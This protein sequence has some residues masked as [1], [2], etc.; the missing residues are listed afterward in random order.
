MNTTLDPLAHAATVPDISS[1]LAECQNAQNNQLANLGRIRWG[2]AERYQWRDGKDGTGA[3]WQRNVSDRTKIVRPYDGCPD[4]DAQITDEIC[5]NEVDLDLTAHSMAQLGAT[6]THITPLTAQA[7]A[8]LTAVGR[9]VQ[10]VIKDDLADDEE[11]LAQMKATMG[12]G[13]LNPGWLE[14]YELVERTLDLEGFINEVAAAAGPDDAKMLYT[15]ILDPTLEA[16]AMEAVQKLFSYLPKARTRQIVRDLRETGQAV[17]LDKQLSEKR[18]TLRTLIPGFNYFV[19]GSTDKIGKARLHL[20]IERYYQADLEATAADAGW[21]EAFVQRAL[22]TAGAFSSFSEKMKQK[23]V[24]A[25]L[26]NADRSIEIWTTSVLQFDPDTGAAGVYCTVFSPHITPGSNESTGE[27]HYA[28]HYLLDYAHRQPPFILARREVTGPSM[29]D[30]RSV[31][32]ITVTNAAVIR[33]LQKAGLARAHLEVNPPRAFIGFGGSKIT[34]WN[35]PGAK[36]ES[37]MPGADVKDLGPARGNPAVGE[38][39]IERVE[40][41]THRLFAFP[42]AEVHP[43]RWQPRSMRKSKRALIPWREA[44]TQ[45]VVLCYQNLTEYE[46]AEIIGHWPVLKLEDV[47]HHKITLTFD[48]RGLDNDWR[49]ETLATLTQLLQ[50]DKGGLMD[51][52]LMIKLIGSL[53]DP[54]MMDAIIQSPAG[55]SAKLYKK[56]S[57]DIIEIMAGNPPPLVEMDAT[58]EMQMKMAMQIVGQNQRYQKALMMDPQIQENFKTYMENLQHSNQETQISPM[59]GRLGVTQMPQRPVQ[60]GMA[61]LNQGE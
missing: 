47:L 39:A 29:F 6:T 49:K 7:L 26:D 53:T 13:I 12:I 51:T 3:L 10:S 56:V 33:N 24:E 4:P 9:W 48:P 28:E 34:D 38:A 17:F 55:A 60:H 43:A 2:E 41:G 59:Q 5:E 21:N 35:T 44:Y 37:L 1:L 32:D 23:Q 36:I 58:A 30:S 15:A 50:I 57:S 46:L 25:E 27:E 8:E 52:G 61:M 22:T 11:L 45:L 14:K 31:P 18:P 42:D 20:V 19:A 54:T 16:M 40:R